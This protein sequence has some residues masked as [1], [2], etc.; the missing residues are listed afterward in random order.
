MAVRRPLILLPG[1]NPE[2]QELPQGDT[3]PGGGGAATVYT[4]SVDM[5]T[6]EAPTVTATIAAAGVNALSKI[7]ICGVSAGAG[8]A[9]DEWELAPVAVSVASAGA[10]TLT[11]F[12]VSIGGGA[13][14]LYNFN[15][16]IG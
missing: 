3:L 1:A 7:A 11:V 14:G 10:G 15:Y 13:T 4:A 16:L 12:A 5:G 8:R 6:G 9:A 2:V